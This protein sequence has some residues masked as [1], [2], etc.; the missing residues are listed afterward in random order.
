MGAGRQKHVAVANLATQEQ[1]RGR[2]GAKGPE[3]PALPLSGLF[4]KSQ[5]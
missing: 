1:S 4:N 5:R 2:V 3:G